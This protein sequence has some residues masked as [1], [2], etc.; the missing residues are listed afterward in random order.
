[1]VAAVDLPG[2]K[3]G[4]LLAFS[5]DQDL[6]ADLNTLCVLE[7][8][9]GRSWT[10]LSISSVWAASSAGGGAIGLFQIAHRF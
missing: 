1:M 5:F 4:D 2:L 9:R 10:A 8:R 6:T 7:T 3:L